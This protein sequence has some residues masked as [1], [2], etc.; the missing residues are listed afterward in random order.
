VG[1]ELIRWAVRTWGTIRVKKTCREKRKATSTLFS[2]KRM[3]K[4]RK[5]GTDHVG[6]NFYVGSSLVAT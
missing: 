2:N 3:S 1:A 6:F 5:T 4:E